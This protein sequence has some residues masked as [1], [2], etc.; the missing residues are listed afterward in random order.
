MSW[1]ASNLLSAFLLPPFN[2]IL[3]GA[4]GRVAP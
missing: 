2:V 4:M 1:F 3:L